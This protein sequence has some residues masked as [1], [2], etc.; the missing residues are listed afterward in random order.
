MQLENQLF[1]VPAT[2]TDR[3]RT[4][5]ERIGP[6]AVLTD[7]GASGEIKFFIP[8]SSNGLLSLSDVFLE[9]EVAIQGKEATADWSTIDAT[10]NI[11]PVNNFLHSL[12]QSVHVTLANRV[13]SDSAN[14]YPY[15]AY[16]ETILKYNAQ[17][18][19]SQLSA[20]GFERDTPRKFNSAADN[21]GELQRK[22][23]FSSGDYIQLSGKLFTDIF[24]Q[25]K[26][27][28]T[29]VPLEVRLVMGKPEFF[30][31]ETAD[32][33]TKQYRAVVRNPRLHVRRY[34]PAPDF[35][36]AVAD[37]LQ[38]RTVKYHIER[39]VM[40]VYDIAAG[41]Q[42]SQFSNIQIGQLPKAVFVG[43]VE[44]EDFHGKGKTSPFNFQHCNVSQISVEVDGQS[45]PSKPYRADFS[46]KS[47]LECYDGLLDALGRRGDPTG[48]FIVDRKGYENGY[49]IFGFDLTPGATGL[50]PLTLIKQG[51]LSVAV[52]FGGQTGLTKPLMM[53]CM[54]VYDS[55]LEINQH[56]QLIA[57]FTT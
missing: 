53:V 22:E 51:N 27:L 29:G 3:W 30:L 37:E 43:F 54:L 14:Y 57:D 40:R 7:G 16:L 21:V 41:I 12:F 44:S 4:E 28:I 33:V 35:M 47:S 50:G 2:F 1:T 6:T 17:A 20:S 13:I 52:T 46:K 23:Y 24:M 49:T 18:I 48:E 32:G 36:L 10:D 39:T 34:I 56:R 38:Q 11:A 31:R 45:F 25:S 15:R 26:P 42:T 5:H 9:L 19:A 8:P 55:I